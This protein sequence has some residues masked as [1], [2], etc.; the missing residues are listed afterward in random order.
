[1]A[2]V[3]W[4]HVLIFEVFVALTLKVTVFWSVILFSLKVTHQ[5]IRRTY[6]LYLGG[7]RISHTEQNR[8][9]TASE[10]WGNFCQITITSYP[11]REAEGSGFLS[12][13]FNDT[14]SCL[15]Y[16]ALLIDGWVC[17]TGGFMLTGENRS[18]KGKAVL[19]PLCPPK[20]P[21]VLACDRTWLFT[22]KGCWLDPWHGH[23]KF[24]RM[25]VSVYQTI[26][27]LIPE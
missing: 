1:M 3:P 12:V 25:L 9:S 21:H 7:Q 22:V 27:H 17:S 23:G 20:V 26:Q 8:G 2:F 16:V 19:V 11:R 18:A 24:L 14:V 5:H 6:C 15:K 13:L 10:I 4:H